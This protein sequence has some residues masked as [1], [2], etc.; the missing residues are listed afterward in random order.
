MSRKMSS[1][2]N[3]WKHFIQ[4]VNWNNNN[5][6]GRVIFD[7]LISIIFLCYFAKVILGSPK[8]KTTNGACIFSSIYKKC[9]ENNMHISYLFVSS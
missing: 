7:F 4:I 8:L 9:Q 1:T 3:N 2:K 6:Q 5:K